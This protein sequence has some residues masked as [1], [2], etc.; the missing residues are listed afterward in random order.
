MEL[1]KAPKS[2]MTLHD[3]SEDVIK[4]HVALYTFYKAVRG[5][6]KPHNASQGSD[7]QHELGVALLQ[8]A[9]RGV[10]ALHLRVHLGQLV[11]R[12]PVLPRHAPVV[13]AQ[14]HHQHHHA[15]Q[16]EGREPTSAAIRS[17]PDH[18][19]TTNS[20]GPGKRKGGGEGVKKE[21]R[22]RNCTVYCFCGQRVNSFV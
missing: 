12:A 2:F 21:A 22:A 7:L 10:R 4:L 8:A 13:V 9:A 19:D 20:S 16:D 11:Q 14:Q 15:D 3:A 6:I 1:D 17:E 18:G 5:F